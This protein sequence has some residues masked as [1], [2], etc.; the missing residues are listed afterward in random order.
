MDVELSKV[1]AVWLREIKRYTNSKARMVSS[2]GQPLLFLVALGGGLSAMMPG[3]NYSGFILPGILAMTLLFTSIFAGVSIIWDRE[4]GFLKEML[5]A[6]AS[7][8]T[9]VIGRTLGGATTAIIQGLMI[10]VLGILITGTPIP[11]IMNIIG[12][13]AMMV[14]FSCFL[15]SLG[16]AI[17]SMIQEVE[18]FQ[19]IMNLLIMPLFFLSNALFPL[20]KM[21]SWL[22][23]ISSLNPISYAVDGLRIMM[24]GSGTFGLFTDFAVSIAGLVVFVLLASHLFSKTSI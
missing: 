19:L 1:Y 9:L 4:F 8:Q 5:A 14:I 15:V 11:S 23:M 24:I 6:P 2:L 7:R 12:I 20:D 16:I 17:A 13:L 3:F 18:T 10:L 21:P 22:Q